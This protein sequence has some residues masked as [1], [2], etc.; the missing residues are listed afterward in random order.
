MRLIYRILLFL[1]L[2]FWTAGVFYNL[3]IILNDQFILFYPII[4]KSYSLVCH[5]QHEKLFKIFGVE[6]L[7][8]SRCTGIYL[9]MLITSFVSIF[10]PIKKEHK[11]KLL[12]FFSLPMFA[13]VFLTSLG[14]YEYNHNLA[15]ATGLF[16]GS[17]GFLYFYSAVKNLLTETQTR[18]KF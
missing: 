16:F 5:Q 7:V 8:C 18:E 11:I 6:T 14:I 3:L 15:L 10:L 9:G 1:L 17:A 2:A 4:K 13:D 12:L